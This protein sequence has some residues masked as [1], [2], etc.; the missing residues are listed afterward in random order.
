M[1]DD[2]ILAPSMEL[3]AAMSSGD[4]RVV[5]DCFDSPIIQGVYRALLIS[6]AALGKR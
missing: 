2:P 4:E 6:G 1:T 3:Y 5:Y